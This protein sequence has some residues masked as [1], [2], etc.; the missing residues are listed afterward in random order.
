MKS[1]ERVSTYA[2]VAAKI[3]IRL[4]VVKIA[5][6]R[7]KRAENAMMAMSRATMLWMK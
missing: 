6:V 5:K 3:S 4:A 7:E 2:A 1:N